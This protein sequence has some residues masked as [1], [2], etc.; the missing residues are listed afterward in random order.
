MQIFFCGKRTARLLLVILLGL[1]AAG[2]GYFLFR[3]EVVHVMEPIYQGSVDKK[4]MALAIN[5][6]WGED[7]LPE[8]L[9]IFT[10]EKVY[11]TFFVTGRFA[12]KFPESVKKIE[13]DGHEIGNHGYSHGHP[14]QTGFL[15][16]QEQIKKTEEALGA[17]VAKP[18]KLFAPPYGECSPKVVEAAEKLGYKTIMWTVDTVDWRG[19]SPQQIAK[20]V[21]SNAQNGA[22]VLM[23][24]KEVTVEALPIMIKEL[25]KQGYKFKKISQII[26]GRKSQN[27]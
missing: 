18:A 9:D 3:Q 1:L 11:A 17:I 16:N 7:I 2:G 20:K 8:M 19:G 14:D 21:V 26:P 25:K 12:E 22:I 13:K 10:K 24:P 4:E 5:V 15:E 6:D 27:N 23:H